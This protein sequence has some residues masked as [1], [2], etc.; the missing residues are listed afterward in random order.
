MSY[1]DIVREYSSFPRNSLSEA[2]RFAAQV[3]DRA[4]VAA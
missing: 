2:L 3:T 1:E 4:D